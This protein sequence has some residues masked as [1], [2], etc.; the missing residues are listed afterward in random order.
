[1]AKQP[2]KSGEKKDTRSRKLRDL[3]AKSLGARKAVSVRGGIKAGKDRTDY[4]V[5]KMNDVLVSGS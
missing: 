2:T 4:L 5:I 1:M 3:P